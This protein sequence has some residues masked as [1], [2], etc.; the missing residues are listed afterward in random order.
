MTERL[1][2]VF[3][4]MFAGKTEEL[5]RLVRR[6]EI[7]QEKV[8]VFKPIIDVRWGKVN[9]I[10]SHNGN[11]HPG[12]PIEKSREILNFLEKDTKVVAI[13][14]VQFFDKEIVAVVRRLLDDDIKVLITGLPLDFRG[15]PF[16]EMPTLMAM[17]DEM[18]Q[19]TAICTYRSPNGSRCGC[20]T[21][22]RTQ[23]LISGEP[24]NYNDPIIKIGAEE[25]YEARCPD[26]H[27]VPGK[28]QI[29]FTSSE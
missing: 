28:P 1:H 24:A 5:I 20:M 3:G 25:S 11:E 18:T 29:V 26:H 9:H 27:L 16:G 8:Q 2:V 21:A 19:L 15:E 23:R 7:A 12:I 17:A 6:F 4:P 14:E 10:A 13:D 22:T